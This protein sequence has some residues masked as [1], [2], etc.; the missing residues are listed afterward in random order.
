MTLSAAAYLEKNKLSSSG[1]WL[2]LLKIKTPGGTIFR[3]SN[4]TE[5]VTWPVTDGNDYISF[6]FELDDIEETAKEVPQLVIRVANVTRVMQGYM[7]AEDGLVNS[8]VTLRVVHTT[9]VTTDVLGAGINNT[10]PE[11]ELFWDIMSSSA[12][13]IWASFVVGAPTPYRLRFPRSRMLVGF[14]RYR[15]FKGVRCKYTGPDETCNRAL[16]TCRLKINAGGESNSINFGG[17]PG[18]GSRGIYV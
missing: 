10:N 14:C 4:N 12:D 17:T 9:H 2:V 1:A 3:I 16:G 8:E 7:E 11:V 18:V 6:P 13:S 5:D 15:Y